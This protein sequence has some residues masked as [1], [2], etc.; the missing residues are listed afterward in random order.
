MGNRVSD[1]TSAEEQAISHDEAVCMLLLWVQVAP[2][3]DAV[4]SRDAVAQAWRERWHSGDVESGC[5]D[6]RSE[7]P[8][9][10]GS[11]WRVGVGDGGCRSPHEVKAVNGFPHCWRRLEQ[12]ERSLRCQ[13]GG[14]ELKGGGAS[15]TSSS[16]EAAHKA[17]RVAVCGEGVGVVAIATDVAVDEGVELRQLGGCEGVEAEEVHQLRLQVL[18]ADVRPSKEGDGV[19]GPLQDRLADKADPGV[20]LVLASI[21]SVA[22]AADD[23]AQ[24]VDMCVLW[25]VGDAGGGTGVGGLPG[26]RAEQQGLGLGGVELGARGGSE[27]GDRSFDDLV[28]VRC[29][30]GVDGGVVG[31]HVARGSSSAKGEGDGLHG[32][33]GDHASSEGGKSLELQ[34]V[35]Q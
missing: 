14:E 6:G 11:G 23:D 1:G 18:L 26:S 21:D 8:T 9:V 15:A 34:D 17:L 4:S 12:A 35:E 2:N 31:V 25:G 28:A 19:L 13:G 10:K 27:G 22:A 7:A 5:H 20:D 24:M 3:P 16:G 33:S 30:G 29:G 32:T